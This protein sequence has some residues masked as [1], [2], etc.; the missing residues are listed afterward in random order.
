MECLDY[1]GRF[2][3]KF[4][5]KTIIELRDSKTGKLT[6]RTEDNNML[7]NALSYFYKQGGL[8]NP[9]A[10]NNSNVRDNPL[11]YLLGGV[12][13]LDTALS[14]SASIIRV[15][16]GVGMTANGA[17]GILNSG[18]PVELGS[19]N[20]TESIWL[21]DGSYK[22]VYDWNTSQGN[23]TIA[24]VCLSS[25]YGA[26]KGI[27]NKSKTNKQT[28]SQMTNYNSIVEY[29][30]ANIESTENSGIGL[31]NNVL[32]HINR[33]NGGLFRDDKWSISKYFFSKSEANVRYG[34]ALEGN[35]LD[36]KEVS[37]SFGLSAY[38]TG[39]HAYFQDGKYA[40]LMFARA[41]TS[42]SYYTRHFT[43]NDSY[44]TK[45]FKY[46]LE[47]DT[48]VQQWNLTPSSTGVSAFE[49]GDNVYPTLLCD[50]NYAVYHNYIFD[51]S[52][53]TNVTE[54]QNFTSEDT[55]LAPLGNGIAESRTNRLDLVNGVI[56]PTNYPNGGEYSG[57][58]FDGLLGYYGKGMFRDPR[59]IATINNLEAPV[60]K[61]PDKTMKVT[62]V[63]SF[64]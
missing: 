15:P 7:T 45:I 57:I 51:L 11:H 36:T 16:P 54:I 39:A 10:F 24:C 23:G 12:L 28:D 38:N 31:H 41:W 17:R 47:T 34:R 26:Y 20:E 21:S 2:I 55:G 14:E 32:T 43:F 50:G 62:Y 4:K 49:L 33:V 6:Q 9:S 42:G 44:P 56:L 37:Y 48:I 61:T 27:G 22:M 53:L 3:M 58:N 5:G 29:D 60:V 8:T 13:C 18:T 63:I 40:Y 35:I 1:K 46:D 25:Y 64:S 59:Y 30:F 52:N 19:W